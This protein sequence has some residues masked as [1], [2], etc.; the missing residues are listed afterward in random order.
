MI[1]WPCW[2]LAAEPLTT[3]WPQF[4][5]RSPQRDLYTGI[6]YWDIANLEWN[7]AEVVERR[8]VRGCSVHH[9]DMAMYG[10]KGVNAD[11][12]LVQS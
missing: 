9:P 7:A 12:G 8:V 2:G 3:R 10:R 5:S 1:R 11:L 4:P 6:V